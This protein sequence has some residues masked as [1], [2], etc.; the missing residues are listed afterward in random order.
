MR[1]HPAQA[2][3]DMGAGAGSD[4]EGAAPDG[5]EEVSISREGACMGRHAWGG[6][7]WGGACMG[8]MQ[9]WGGGGAGMGGGA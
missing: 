6:H 7:A 2:D 3:E 9:A 8:G 5:Q 4:D 1:V